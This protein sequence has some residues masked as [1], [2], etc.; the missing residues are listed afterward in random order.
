MPKENDE[1][2]YNEGRTKQLIGA[3]VQI[4]GLRFKYEVQF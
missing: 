2:R 3:T 1:L 4:V